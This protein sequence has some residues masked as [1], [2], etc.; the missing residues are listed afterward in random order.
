MKRLLLTG[1]AG[2]P[3]ERITA[4]DT[5]GTTGFSPRDQ[6]EALAAYLAGPD[7]PGPDHKDGD[8]P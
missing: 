1:G 3:D 8:H 4:L 6:H 7:V 5:L 2:T